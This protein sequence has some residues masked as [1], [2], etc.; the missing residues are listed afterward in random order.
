MVRLGLGWTV[1]PTAVP[2]GGPEPIVVG[3][4]IVERVL[5]LARRAGTV[6]DPAV[7]ELEHRL[8]TGVGQPLTASSP[9]PSNTR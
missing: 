4:E 7:T 9:S 6:R 8:Q 2:T 1:L 3:P 5:V